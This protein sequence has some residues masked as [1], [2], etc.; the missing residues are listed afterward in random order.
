MD[1]QLRYIKPNLII[2]DTERDILWKRNNNPGQKCNRAH[3]D[4]QLYV[5]VI[6]ATETFVHNANYL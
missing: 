2:M 4:H 6:G 3:Q 1:T 5:Y